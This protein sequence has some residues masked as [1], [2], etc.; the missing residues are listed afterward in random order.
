M[1]YL[2]INTELALANFCQQISQDARWIAIDTEFMRTNTF[3]AE[4]SLIQIQ[5][6]Q[7]EAA[8]IDPIA[9]PNLECLWQLLTDKNILKVFHAA[10]QD[11]EV[12][13]QVAKRMPVSIFDTQIAALFLGHGNLAGLSR[14]LDKELNIQIP[15][16]Q[17]RTD[18]N[19]RPLTKQQLEYA[20]NDV[21]NL[22]P[23][24]QKINQ[25]LNQEQQQAL[26]EDFADLLNPKHY[27]ID[28][29]KAGERIKQAKTLVP[30][31]Q[32]IVNT[33]AQWR[34]VYAIEHNKPRKWILSDD[35]IIA[36]AK[37]PP[38][39]IQALYNVPNIKH[40]S[41]K[42]FGDEWLKL[43]DEVFLTPE[44]WP[45]KTQK[46]KPT[47]SQ[48]EVFIQIGQAIA[49]QV[50][51]DYGINQANL[52]KKQQLVDII[53]NSSTEY[54]IGWKKLLIAKPFQ[55]FLNGKQV[56]SADPFLSLKKKTNNHV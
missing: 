11:I 49:Q 25:S 48:E 52:I 18:W 19:Q 41:V 6:E 12:L 39:T 8:I 54:L 20:F 37:R 36:I 4:L 45:A 50:Y 30:K 38:Q 17:T 44:S 47:T 27:Q 9:I 1:S 16:D 3:F 43:I 53:R 51:I 13:Y 21:K 42:E 35:A 22:A 15:K 56:I 10:R 2:Y 23:L 29:N 14:V 7:G 55:E 28:I 33:L 34:E 32:A 40:S 24:Y 5:S 26:L 31:Q 46:T